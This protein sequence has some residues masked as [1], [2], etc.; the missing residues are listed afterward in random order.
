MVRQEVAEKSVKAGTGAGYIV[1]ALTGSGLGAAAAV[2]LNRITRS[3]ADR[4]AKRRG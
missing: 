1:G 2:V 3:R 4:R